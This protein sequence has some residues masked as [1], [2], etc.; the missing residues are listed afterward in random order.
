MK[1]LLVFFVLFNLS[2]GFP[3]YSF[4][5]YNPGYGFQRVN[6]FQR[7]APIQVI[8]RAPVYYFPQRSWVN[9]QRE[10]VTPKPSG[11]IRIQSIDP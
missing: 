9:Y 3:Q 2:F 4:T 5:I 6:T 7:F 1:A 10:E 8:Q 11:T